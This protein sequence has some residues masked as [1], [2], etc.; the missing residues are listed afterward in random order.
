M[1]RLEGITKV[2]GGLIALEEVSF[3][4]EDG[5]ITGIIGPNGAGKTT[6]FNIVSG[7]YPQNS[8]N[9]Y[10]G[11]GN[12]SR[13]APEK[14]ARLGLVRTFQ[15]VEL[16]GQMTVLENV[17]VGLHTK[18]KSGILSCAFKLPGHIREEKYIR[19]R[20]LQWL[21]FTG[22]VDSA[23][24]KAGN[25][26][27]GQ[28]RLLEIARALA[29]EPRMILMDEPAAGLNSHE[30]I[31]LAALIRRIR[32]SGVTVVLVEHDMDLVMDVCDTVVVLNLGRKLAE[33]TPREIQENTAVITAYLGEG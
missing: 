8:G 11:G 1:L 27:F 6:L 29:L 20:G 17:M 23:E 28:G 26:P 16:F 10:L 30:T 5:T 25:L 19:E 18:S 3:S 14:L 31:G 33:G 9:V 15:N 22:M 4:V 13:F 12:I 2:F 24:V 21:E 7:I 32:E